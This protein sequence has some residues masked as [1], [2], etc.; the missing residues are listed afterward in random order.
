MFFH[1]LGFCGLLLFRLHLSYAKPTQP[2]QQPTHMDKTVLST[3]P[4]SLCKSKPALCVAV[5]QNIPNQNVGPNRFKTKQAPKK[6]Q[7]PVVLFWF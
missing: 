4:R 3:P 2:L 1:Y 7:E 6:D 5:N